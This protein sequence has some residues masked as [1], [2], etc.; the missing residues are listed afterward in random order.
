MLLLCL[1]KSILLERK[2]T[3]LHWEIRSWEGF[4]PQTNGQHRLLRPGIIDIHLGTALQIQKESPRKADDGCPIPLP[5]H[6]AAFGRF[7]SPVLRHSVAV[8]ASL[9]A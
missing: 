8:P 2:L 3:A 9:R 4:S 1:S 6:G 7:F 5:S